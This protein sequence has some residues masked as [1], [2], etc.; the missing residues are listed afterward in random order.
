MRR[1][2]R[3]FVGRALYDPGKT[4]MIMLL[5]SCFVVFIC[6]LDLVCAAGTY[7]KQVV[8]NTRFFTSVCIKNTADGKRWVKGKVLKFIGDWAPFPGNFTRYWDRPE[9]EVIGRAEECNKTY[10]RNRVPAEQRIGKVYNAQVFSDGTWISGDN[11]FAP[12]QFRW[13]YPVRG[14]KKRKA[15]VIHSATATQYVEKGFFAVHLYNR[16]YFH[17]LIELFPTIWRLYHSG[18]PENVVVVFSQNNKFIT[19]QILKYFN[20]SSLPY[21]QFDTN[22]AVFV[23]ELY[24]T[25]PRRLLQLDEDSLM[26]VRDAYLKTHFRPSGKPRWMYQKHFRNRAIY[27]Y[28]EL[29]AQIHEKYDFIKFEVPLA[30][31]LEHQIHIY[32]DCLIIMGPHGAAFAN[33]MWMPTKA[34]VI[35]FTNSYCH[36]AIFDLA[37]ILGMKYYV[38][39][40]AN[41]NAHRD[42]VCEIP[43]VMSIIDRAVVHLRETGLL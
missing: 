6:F 17:F 12:F 39:R 27:K 24:M 9:F 29:L 1:V 43:L 16:G 20:M 34:V 13:M 25:P 31:S 42:T 30:L 41:A 38:T 2:L 21:V 40:F 23:K 4:R 5:A 18:N 37:T 32:Q 7:R 33:V 15:S 35:E 10:Y 26:M 28:E 8:F 3:S 36:S 19:N 11:F 22:E 14:D